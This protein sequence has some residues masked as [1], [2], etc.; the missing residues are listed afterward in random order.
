MSK[1]LRFRECLEHLY[2]YLKRHQLKLWIG[3]FLVVLM[4]VIYAIMPS[5]EGQI[6]SQLQYDIMY[7]DSH[8]QMDKIV[9]ILGILLCIFFVKITSQFVSAFF[10]TDSIQKT[11]EDIRQSVQAKINHLPVQYFDQQETGD[12]LSRITNDVETLS[13]ALQQTLSRVIGAVCTFFFV[14]FMMFR[15]NLTMTLIVYLALPLI[16]L[17]SFGLIKR[18]QPLFDA[19]QQS[20]SIL[21]SS[22]NELY[23]GF[24]EIMAY[25]QQEQAKKSFDIANDEM[26][27]TGF[28]AQFASGLISPSTSLVTYITIG[29]VAWYGCLQVL[30]G[31]ILLGELQAFIRYIWNIN[32]PIA[33]LSQLSSAVQSA[34]SAMNRL[35]T[36]LAMDELEDKEEL[37]LIH[38]VDTIEFDHVRF[39]YGEEDLM[40]DISFQVHRGERVAIVGPTGAGKTTLTNLLLRFY[41]VKEGSIKIN[42]IDIRQFSYH[43]LRDLFGLV[44]QDTWLFE[45][46]IFENLKYGNPKADMSD[47]VKASKQANVH[48]YIHTL[49]GGYESMINESGSNISQGEKQLLTIARALLKDPQILIL[50]EATS[51]VDTRLEVRLQAAMEEVMKKRT[52]FVI[53]HRLSTI[54]NA[55]L[56]L[57]M[58]HGTI[59]ETGRHEELL[60]KKGAYYTLYNAQFSQQ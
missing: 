37:V 35:F 51:S 39:G 9:H 34:F 8:I 2:P 40:S 11:M 41:D 43:Q 33:Q 26:R 54:V 32:D 6:T 30:S 10:L 17:I 42:G 7:R 27:N 14:S 15:I 13:N 1:K 29:C 59:I 52:S 24:D 23:S 56:I 12:L 38:E 22:V 36:F 3:L 46:S 53:A 4:Q 47:V 49:K 44:L 31:T 58:E 50:D 57:V 60:A 16:A 19:Q 45:G 48:H 28:R 21:S 18:S 55:D 20:L 5:V 25:N